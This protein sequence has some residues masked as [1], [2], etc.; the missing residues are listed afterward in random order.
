LANQLK[1][2]RTDVI[3]NKEL[4]APKSAAFR[5]LAGTAILGGALLVAACDETHVTIDKTTVI[6]NY[7]TGP[8]AGAPADGAVTTP[9]TSGLDASA[10]DTTNNAPEA[11]VAKAD[12]CVPSNVLPACSNGP[13]VTGIVNVGDGLAIGAYK[14]QLNDLEVN[15]STTGAI[16]SVLDSCGNVVIQGVIPQGETK[17]VQLDGQTME[18]TA[19]QVAPGY[20][21]GTKWADMSIAIPCP[22]DAG[23]TFFCSGADGTVNQGESL[24]VTGMKVTLDDFMVDNGATY[25]LLS[26]YDASN[27]LID[28]LKIQEGTST[29]LSTGTGTYQIS[30]PTIGAGETFAAKWA[31]IDISTV[32]E[33][34]CQ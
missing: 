34:P 4:T 30:V 18:V 2:K 29:I 25:A 12:A 9:K 14:L 13:A 20:T 21:F 6:N 27:N 33:T 32:S 1:L 17:E 24:S 5:R 26:A 10:P 3:G 19:V 15:G 11:P 31:T 28:K 7:T 8:D 22:S 16:V 23:T